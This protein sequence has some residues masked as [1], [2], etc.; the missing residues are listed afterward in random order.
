MFF[1]HNRDHALWSRRVQRDDTHD[2][3]VNR[4][5]HEVRVLGESTD[6]AVHGGPEQYSRLPALSR[7]REDIPLLVAHFL[8]AI[9]QDGA[10]LPDHDDVLDGPLRLAWPRRRYLTLR[11]PVPQT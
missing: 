3:V 8:A 6:H 11:H 1:Q 4:W 10:G 2:Q 7:R 5:P 9:A